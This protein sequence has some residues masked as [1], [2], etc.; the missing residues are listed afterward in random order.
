MAKQ[1]ITYE[2]QILDLVLYAG[3]GTSFSLTVT[4]PDGVPI[5]LTGS[6]IAQIR[7]ARETVDPP[8]AE[9]T[10]DLT[11][12]ALGIAVLE[13]T[14]AETHALITP[15]KFEGVWDIQWTPSGGEPMTLCQGKV[16]CYP[17]VSH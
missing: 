10:I 3:D 7:T 6:M 4:D 8:S 16:E 2:P 5:N 11:D 17:D 15:E 12:A 9:F 13:L 1:K 14:G